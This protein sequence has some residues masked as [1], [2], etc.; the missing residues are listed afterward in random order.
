VGN[1]SI[2]AKQADGTVVLFTV[3]L[4]NNALV[5]RVAGQMGLT[6]VH[7]RFVGPTHPTVVRLGGLGLLWSIFAIGTMSSLGG[8]V[9]LKWI[10]LGIG[11]ACLLTGCIALGLIG[12]SQRKSAPVAEADTVR[13]TN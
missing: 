11:A 4:R 13:R 3:M 12:P 7:Q 1:T 5:A 9:G 10:Q 8:L 2:A 6:S